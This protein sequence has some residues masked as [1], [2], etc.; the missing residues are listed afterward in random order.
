MSIP[1]FSFFFFFSDL[2]AVEVST[3]LLWTDTNVIISDYLSFTLSW[4]AGLFVSDCERRGQGGAGRGKSGLIP[5]TNTRIHGA[6]GHGRAFSESSG[7]I[8]LGIHQ[9]EAGL[10]MKH[11]YCQCHHHH[12]HHHTSSTIPLQSLLPPPTTTT[13][14]TALEDRARWW[15]AAGANQSYHVSPKLTADLM[16]H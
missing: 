16:L 9:A 14:A 1:F 8:T 13:T 3:L 11:M 7:R 4:A 2:C 10:A 12:H 6:M 5:H 15:V